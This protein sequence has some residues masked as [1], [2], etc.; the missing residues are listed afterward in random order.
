MPYILCGK[1]AQRQTSEYLLRLNGPPGNILI[2]RGTQ[3]QKKNGG[4]GMKRKSNRAAALIVACALA[5]MTLTPGAQAAGKEERMLVP[6]GCAVGIQMQTNGVLVVGLS[7]AENGSAPSP[8]AQAGVL[9]GDLIVKMAEDRIASA[10]DFRTAVGK[11]TGDPVKVTVQRGAQTKELTLKPDMKSGAPELGLWLRDNVAGVGTLTYYDPQTG[12]YGCLG[13][14]INDMDS[15][16]MIPLGKGSLYPATIVGVKKSSPG[17]PGELCGDFVAQSACGNILKNSS[18]GVFGLLKANQPDPKKA[19]PAADE[20]EIKLGPAT[21][22]TNV[23]GDQTQSFSVEITRVYR[24][25]PDGRSL[26]LTVK[27]QKL[28]EKAGGI[29]QGM[30]GSPIIQNGKLI[31]AVTHVLVSDP[32]KGFGVS[33]EKMLAES[34]AL[35]T[36]EAA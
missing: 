28:L 35:D 23:G 24:G 15:G 6:M 14:G 26:M 8:A 21:V 22:L 17:T 9:P 3:N 34:E 13:H 2:T 5:L 36:D 32:T 11:L 25:D 19:I 1:A 16:V 30:S 20:N 12:F 31:G 29:V 4:A 7:A 33:I 10:E 27:D 18:C